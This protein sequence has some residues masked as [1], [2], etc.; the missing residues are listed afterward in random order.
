MCWYIGVGRVRVAFTSS[1]TAIAS[2]R[3][4]RI[5]FMID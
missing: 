2:V 4:V 3:Q 5:D 1:S